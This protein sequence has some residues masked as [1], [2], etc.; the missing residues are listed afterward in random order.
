MKRNAPSILANT[1][2]EILD[3][4]LIE[5]GLELYWEGHRR[6][7][8]IRFGKYL[9]PKSNKDF[10]SP[11]TALLCPVPEAIMQQY[12]NYFPQNP[13]YDPF[14]DITDPSIY[15]P[16]HITIVSDTCRVDTASVYLG[17]P[18]IGDNCSIN[19]LVTK[20]VPESY[21]SG[22][23]HILWTV[24]DESGNS[25]T[26]QQIVTIDC[27]MPVKEIGDDQIKIYPNPCNGKFFIVNGR[28][29]DKAVVE[30]FSITGQLLYVKTFIQPEMQFE[31]SL[32]GIEPGLYIIKI[33]ASNTLLTDKIIIQ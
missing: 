32:N 1:Q 13:G 33:S 25:S 12:C 31:I 4:I 24:T 7:D 20:S 17:T 30:V 10:T 27:G 28:K 15:C 11:V 6:Q 14:V 26:C 9:G 22:D 5:R 8:L 2:E 29:A 19:L 21:I 18:T 16:E 23:N 3:K